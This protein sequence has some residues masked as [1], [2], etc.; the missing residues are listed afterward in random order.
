VTGSGGD[1]SVDGPSD[2]APDGEPAVDDLR[3]AA[4]EVV[5]SLKKLLD[6]TERVI[7][8]PDTFAGVVDNGREVLGAFFEGFTA[9]AHDGPVRPDPT[10]G[11]PADGD[12]A[13]MDPADMDPADKA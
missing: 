6:A 11:D 3:A 12:P 4:G 2:E 13:D 7:A 1:A 10:D 9:A 5:A 8:D